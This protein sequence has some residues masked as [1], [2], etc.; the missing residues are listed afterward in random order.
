MNC[1]QFYRKSLRHNSLKR[2]YV[3]VH[4]DMYSKTAQVLRNHKTQEKLQK[5]KVGRFQGGTGNEH[6]R[7]QTNA[8]W[9]HS[10]CLRVNNPLTRTPSCVVWSWAR[11]QY[12]TVRCRCRSET[13]RFRWWSSWCRGTECGLCSIWVCSSWEC[14]AGSLRGIARPSRGVDTLCAIPERMTQ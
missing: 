10:R 1:N 3:Y 11:R 9:R 8:T 4:I 6:T 12:C 2:W 7:E 14:R 13:N 5:I